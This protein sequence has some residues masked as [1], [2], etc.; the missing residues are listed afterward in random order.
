MSTIA[1]PTSDRATIVFCIEAGRL[2]SESL[3]MLESLRRWGGPIGQSRVLAVL[4]RRDRRL[5]PATLAGL[6]SYG[7]E[8]HDASRENEMTWYNWY[9]KVVAVRLADRLATT[10]VVIW[11]DSD[12][13]V[14]R[15]LS[16]L[17]LPNGAEL[18][19]RR[20]PVAPAIREPGSG[21]E[22]FLGY[23]RRAC[24]A[25]G[26]DWD[27]VPWLLAD[28]PSPRQRIAFCAGV[29]A[30]R[31]GLG[32]SEV[33][34]D[35]TRRMIEAGVAY[36]DNVF[37]HNEQNAVMLAMV[38]LGL[39]FR[40]LSR[41]E[42]HMLYQ[43][44]LEGPGAAPLVPDARLVHYSRSRDPEHWPRFMARI[45][46]EL[47]EYHDWLLGHGPLV[48]VRFPRDPA[49]LARKAYRKVYT[50]LLKRKC[51]RVTASWNA[52]NGGVA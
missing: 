16:E 7:V 2:E 12:V 1:E 8:L 5:S 27:A 18:A 34:A 3:L 50:E 10:P 23:W 22:R 48:Q 38:K 26:V 25:V 41:Q 14:L 39:R 31:R 11:L 32:F 36:Y 47:P 40:E 44:M 20:E 6:E 17:G 13:L 52:R 9:N 49:F 30:F 42:H 19:A 29:F 4:P 37:W 28:G 51:S 35:F 15:P 33:Y 21:T 45:R 46:G 43:G 24:D